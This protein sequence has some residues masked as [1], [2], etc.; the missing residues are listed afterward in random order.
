MKRIYKY[1]TALMIMMVFNNLWASTTLETIGDIG[2][3]ALPLTAVGTALFYK[4]FPGF[5]EFGYSYLLSTG[6]VQLLK[7]IIHR[8]RPNHSGH[9]FPSGHT[10]NGFVAAS[11]MQLRYGWAYGAPA[12]AVAA[13]IGYSRIEAKKHWTTDVVAG[14]VIGAGSSFLFTHKYIKV[15]PYFNPENKETGLTAAIELM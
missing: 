15:A 3:I 9:S 13:V 12:Y 11:F 7:H 1:P 2:Q 4:D 10:A 5:T 8:E 6:S 14:A